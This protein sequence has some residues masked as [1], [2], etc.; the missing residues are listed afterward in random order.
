[1]MLAFFHALFVLSLPFADSLLFPAVLVGAGQP[2]T[3]LG[4]ALFA[5]LLLR[6]PQASLRVL[7]R[8]PH[9]RL[10]LALLGVAAVSVFMS[11]AAPISQWKSEILWV[12]S[13]K[14]CLQ[15]AICFCCFAA[16]A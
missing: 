11:A 16:R 15:L 3:F 10:F 2:S 13:L 6:Q 5:T 12:K 1:M 8:D 4:L 9:S 7:F 14:Q